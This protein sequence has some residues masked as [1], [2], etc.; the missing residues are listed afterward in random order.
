MRAHLLKTAA[1]PNSRRA[2]NAIG[3]VPACAVRPNCLAS[4]ADS[5]SRPSSAVRIFIGGSSAGGRS[6][7]G[8]RTRTPSDGSFAIASKNLSA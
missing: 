1:S 5:R 3:R 4:V 2:A 8:T 6:S 7:S